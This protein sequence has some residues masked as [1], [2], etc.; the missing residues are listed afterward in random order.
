VSLLTPATACIAHGSALIACHECIVEILDRNRDRCVEHDAPIR[1]CFQ[2]VQQTFLPLLKARLGAKLR[3][4]VV[5]FDEVWDQVV[6]E[7][8]R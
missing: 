1:F 4:R 5:D 3:E 8:N 6:K 7:L 2:C